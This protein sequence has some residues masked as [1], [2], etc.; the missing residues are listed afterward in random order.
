MMTMKVF[1][2]IADPATLQVVGHDG[3]RPIAADSLNTFPTNVPV[4]PGDILGIN[5]PTSA[6]TAC[7][8]F[9]P[10]DVQLLNPGNLADGESAAFSVFPSD[11]RLNV[12][13]VVEPDADQDGF[14]DETQD[15]CPGQAGPNNGCPP[16]SQGAAPTTPTTPATCKGKQATIVGTTGNDVRK[17]TARKDVIAALGGNDKVS[18]L[19]GDDL[20][21]GGSGKDILKGGKGNDKLLGQAGK[22]TLRGG[23]GNDTLKGGAGKDKQVQ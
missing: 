7:V 11:Y 8:F 19:A 2:R 4:Q 5:Q 10:G 9:A 16:G 6:N 17:G 18:G 1:R 12:S 13:A 20:I 14:G 3:P 22:D 15:Q 21:C 23:P